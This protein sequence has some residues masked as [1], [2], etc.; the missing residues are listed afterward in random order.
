MVFRPVFTSLMLCHACMLIHPLCPRSCAERFG[1]ICNLW[2]QI[3]HG[4]YKTSQSNLGHLLQSRYLSD[5]YNLK[6]KKFLFFSN[7]DEKIILGTE[8]KRKRTLQTELFLTFSLNLFLLVS[9]NKRSKRL[10]ILSYL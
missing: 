6:K 5:L 4:N 7:W 8:M 3:F 10:M 9:P 2:A 1:L